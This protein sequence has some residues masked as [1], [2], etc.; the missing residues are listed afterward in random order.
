MMTP[1]RVRVTVARRGVA[2]RPAS[3]VG[4]TLVLRSRQ[5]GGPALSP[6][7]SPDWAKME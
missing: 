5:A 3:V 6:A 4:H 2:S 7:L 1:K